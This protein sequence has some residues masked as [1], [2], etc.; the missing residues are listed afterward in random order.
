VVAGVSSMGCNPQSLAV[1]GDGVR[2]P[3]AP[4]WWSKSWER[5]H[6]LYVVTAAA[7]VG[8]VSC[9]CTSR[10]DSELL[11]GCSHSCSRHRTQV[12]ST[13]GWG[14]TNSRGGGTYREEN[15]LAR[16]N[17]LLFSVGSNAQ[18]GLAPLHVQSS[19]TSPPARLPVDLL[20]TCKEGRI[21]IAML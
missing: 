4:A 11:T 13:R 19:S 1:V 18:S 21:L 3:A 9:C 6:N 5:A 7:G 16:H 20:S 10:G 12:C 17:D 14:G 15:G 8:A 2:P